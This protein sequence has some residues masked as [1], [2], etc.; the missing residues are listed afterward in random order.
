MGDRG[1][2]GNEKIEFGE[3][4]GRVGE[5]LEVLAK[6]NDV[7]LA[8]ERRLRFADFFLHADEIEIG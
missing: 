5:I 1:V 2:D 3:S 6:L 4:R 7:I 8:Q